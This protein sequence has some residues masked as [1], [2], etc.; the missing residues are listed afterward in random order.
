MTEFKEKPLKQRQEE[1][2]RLLKKYPHKI[3]I[4]LEKNRSSLVG[5]MEKKKFL[6]PDELTV[7]QLLYTIRQRIKIRS[8]E[9]LYIFFNKQ[10]VNTNA[11]MKEIY[12][13]HRS[14]DDDMLYGV[15]ATENT[16]GT[17]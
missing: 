6:V 10:L 1:I 14:M 4:H 12:E 3:P 15:Y 8:E 13:T 2:L 5:D 9:A 16:F 11:L 17:I 7:G